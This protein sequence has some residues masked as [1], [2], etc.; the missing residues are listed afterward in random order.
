MPNMC[1]FK[2]KKIIGWKKNQNLIS[3]NTCLTP[4]GHRNN[5]QWPF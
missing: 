5:I 2:K 1:I 4:I 3:K